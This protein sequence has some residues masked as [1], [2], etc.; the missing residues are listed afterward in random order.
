LAF[1]CARLACRSRIARTFLGTKQ[2]TVT[3]RYSA[4]DIG[5]LIA[6]SEKVCVASDN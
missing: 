1:A 4:T 3:T 6:A 5:N 2:L